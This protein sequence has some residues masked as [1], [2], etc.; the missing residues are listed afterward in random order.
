M[1]I[2]TFAEQNP[3]KLSLFGLEWG[4]EANGDFSFVLADF[5]GVAATLN[6][7]V[8]ERVGATFRRKNKYLLLWASEELSATVR[9]GGYSLRQNFFFKGLTNRN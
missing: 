4:F 2:L 3:D 5:W 6:L 9:V 8:T 1:Q 7:A